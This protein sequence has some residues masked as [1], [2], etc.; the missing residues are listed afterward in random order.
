M[1]RSHTPLPKPPAAEKDLLD[2]VLDLCRGL[3][4]MTSAEIV[5]HVKSCYP[6][7]A[8]VDIRMMLRWPYF[9][10]TEDGWLCRWE[11]G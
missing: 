4:P 5:K 8:A 6:D 2:P 11:L 7:A 3:P 10:L 1:I 9:T